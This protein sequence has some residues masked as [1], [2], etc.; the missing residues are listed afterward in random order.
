MDLTVCGTVD[1]RLVI[2]DHALVAIQLSTPEE[3]RAQATA[4]LFGGLLGAAMAG[5][6]SS[7]L[8]GGRENSL[9][10]GDG[11]PVPP[12]HHMQRI[13]KCFVS[14]VP[15]ELSQSQGWPKVADFRP[16]VFYPRTVIGQVVVRWTGAMLVTFPGVAP[17][18]TTRLNILSVWK[19][20]NGLRRWGYPMG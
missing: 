11:T 2:T 10:L 3:R 13:V 12:L 15:P 5:G 18:F 19:A 9:N 6:G 17:D 8:G 14:E 7:L 4:H 16:V 20:R 1:G